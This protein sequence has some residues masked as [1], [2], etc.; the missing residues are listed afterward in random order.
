MRRSL[1]L[2]VQALAS[3]EGFL[4]AGLQRLSKDILGVHLDKRPE[5]RCGNWEV[6]VLSAEQLDYAAKD[7]HVAVDIFTSY[8]AHI[9]QHAVVD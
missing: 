3:R 2:L 6:E 5:L 1:P 8:A 9:R 7:A 4:A